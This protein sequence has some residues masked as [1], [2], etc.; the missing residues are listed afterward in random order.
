MNPA[1]L[2][3]RYPLLFAIIT[4]R[5]SVKTTSKL[6]ENHWILGIE[7]DVELPEFISNIFK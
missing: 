7:L 5:V 3:V 6:D 1:L 2:A 4:E